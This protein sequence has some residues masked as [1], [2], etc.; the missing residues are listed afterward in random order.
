[1]N[2]NGGERENV[3][4]RVRVNVLHVDELDGGCVYDAARVHVNA[5][6]V[7]VDESE[8]A[9]DEDDAGVDDVNVDEDGDHGYDLDEDDDTDD[10]NVKVVVVPEDVHIQQVQVQVQVQMTMMVQ[11]LGLV[12]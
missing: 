4:V 10:E 3:R 12:H 1:V 5:R 7:G 6:H 8:H 11:E 2:E 9:M